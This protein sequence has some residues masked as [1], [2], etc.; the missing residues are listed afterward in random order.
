M[1]FLRM[2]EEKKLE[3]ENKKKQQEQNRFVKM[4]TGKNAFKYEDSSDEDD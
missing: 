4:L 3:E 2:S 1:A